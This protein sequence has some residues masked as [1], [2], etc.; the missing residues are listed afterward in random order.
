VY[1]E[2][3][4]LIALITVVAL[5]LRAF[6]FAVIF[7]DTLTAFV[8]VFFMEDTAFVQFLLLHEE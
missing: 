7:F 5:M 1:E 8:Q 2:R 6:V 3:A 4:I